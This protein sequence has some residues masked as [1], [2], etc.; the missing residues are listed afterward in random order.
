MARTSLNRRT[1]EEHDDTAAGPEGAPLAE[2]ARNLSRCSAS[3]APISTNPAATTVVRDGRSDA[4]HPGGVLKSRSRSCCISERACTCDIHDAVAARQYRQRSEVSVAASIC[5]RSP[6]NLA[7]RMGCKATPV[8]AWSTPT[9]TSHLLE[10]SSSSSLI[11]SPGVASMWSAPAPTPAACCAVAS[12]LLRLPAS[13]SSTFFLAAA[14]A[15]NFYSQTN[16]SR[17]LAGS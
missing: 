7:C 3:S 13:A 17:A 6:D 10:C 14:P 4:S 1:G 11:L 2:A 9:R 12:L 16:S 5:W 15:M 8:T